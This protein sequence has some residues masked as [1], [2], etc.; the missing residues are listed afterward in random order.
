MY[1]FVS[2]FLVIGGLALALHV[3]NNHRLWRFLRGRRR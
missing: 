2:I 3:Y 1:F